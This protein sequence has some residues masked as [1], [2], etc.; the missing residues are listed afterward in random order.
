MGEVLPQ[1]DSKGGRGDAGGAGVSA[2]TAWAMV[3]ANMVGIGVFTSAGFQVEAVPSGFGVLLL[4]LIG[5]LMALCGSLCY[6][7][8]AA[9]LPR[10][11]G[12]YHFLSRIFHPLPG[13]LSGW[14]SATVGFSAPIALAAMA[15]ADYLGGAIPGLPRAPLAVGL[16]VAAAAAHSFDLRFG[17]A[18]QG[19][20]TWLKVLLIAGLCAALFAAGGSQPVHFTPRAGDAAL[21]FSAPFAISLVFVMYSYSG[22]NSAAYIAGEVRDPGRSLPLA[23]VGGALAVTVLYV[24]VNSAFLV[25]APMPAMAGKVEVALVASRH[26]LGETGARI[27]AALIGVGLIST[28]SAMTWAG[29]RVSF[30][31]GEDHRALR[32]LAWRNRAGLPI[33]ALWVQTALAL[34]MLLTSSFRSILLYVEFV[35][36]VPLMMTVLGVIWLRWREPGLPRPFRVWGYP[37]TPLIFLGMEGWFIVALLLRQPRESIAGITTL[38][39]GA[40]VYVVAARRG[41][42]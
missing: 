14:V 16:V 23:L 12:E 38:L 42:S 7:E 11:G 17:A 6:A 21:V 18:V 22:W 5:G 37:L 41:R 27:A 13:F 4:W 24:L 3:V 19:I 35:L 33:V 1:G 2:G 10:S 40:L 29:P 20:S 34:G 26:A 31:M 8:L 25:S 15:F 28:V 30:A 36:S 32:F 39:L 9:A